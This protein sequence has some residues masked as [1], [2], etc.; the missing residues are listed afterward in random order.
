MPSVDTGEYLTP[1]MLHTYLNRVR[2]DVVAHPRDWDIGGYRELLDPRIRYRD[3]DLDVLMDLLVIE[4]LSRCQHI[5]TGWV[6]EGD[7]AENPQTLMISGA[8]VLRKIANCLYNSF[9][10]KSG[11]LAAHRK[12]T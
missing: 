9:N 8:K 7:N 3:A 2:A 10:R 1:F 5:Y 4:E 11:R 12:R 6:G